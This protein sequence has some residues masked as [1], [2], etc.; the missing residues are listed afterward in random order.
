MANKG[1]LFVISGPSGAG[2]STVITRLVKQVNH[3]YFSVSATTREPRRGEREGIDY[4]FISNAEFERLIAE[5]KLL[6]YASYVGH[7]YGTPAEPV[8]E[9]LSEGFDVVLDIETKGAA[10][11]MEKRPDA[12]GIFLFPGS[13]EI[14]RQRLLLRSTDSPEVIERRMLQAHVECSRA[15]MYKYIIINDRV[16]TAVDEAIAI[17]TAEKCKTADRLHLLK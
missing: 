16:E 9:K 7:Y 2:K 13:Y 11:V 8:D 5:E 17:M 4:R 1:K 12:I 10:Q 15:E 6:E 14:L 3:V